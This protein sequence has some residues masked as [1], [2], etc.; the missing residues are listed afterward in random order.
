MVSAEAH[1]CIGHQHPPDSAWN[2]GIEVGMTID[3]GLDL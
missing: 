1:G 2:L 3:Q